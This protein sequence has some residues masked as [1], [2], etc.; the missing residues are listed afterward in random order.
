MM[1]QGNLH[2]GVTVDKSVLNWYSWQK[3]IFLSQLAMDGGTTNEPIW[4]PVWM[5]FT[6]ML[7]YE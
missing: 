4:L 7:A 2:R 5:L 6:V 3:T 1:M